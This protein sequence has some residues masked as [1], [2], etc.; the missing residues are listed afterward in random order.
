MGTGQKRNK[1]LVEG[2]ERGLYQFKYE[3]ADELGIQPPQSDYWGNLTSRDCGA[4]G[5]NMVRKMIQAYETQL[6]NQQNQ[7]Q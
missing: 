7:Q 3:V 5:G 1:A 2:A 4:V 6:A